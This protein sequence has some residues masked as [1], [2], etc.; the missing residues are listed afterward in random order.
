MNQ[1]MRSRR[2][3]RAEESRKRK[4]DYFALSWDEL[5]DLAKHQGI[6]LHHMKRRDVENAL[7]AS[8]VER[9]SE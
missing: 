1:L 9:V 5:R 8:F 7:D 2:V 6:N 4:S 3:R